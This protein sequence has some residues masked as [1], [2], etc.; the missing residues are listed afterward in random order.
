MIQQSAKQKLFQTVEMIAKQKW[1]IIWPNQHNLLKKKSE[2]AEMI[3]EQNYLPN[4][5]DY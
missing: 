1:S 2:I 3:V 5:N 4:K